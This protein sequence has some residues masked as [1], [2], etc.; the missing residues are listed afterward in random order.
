MRPRV[1][2]HGSSGCQLCPVHPLSLCHCRTPLRACCSA[3]GRWGNRV[4]R[5]LQWEAGSCGG[6]P[7]PDVKA[8]RERMLPFCRDSSPRGAQRGRSP[9]QTWFSQSTLPPQ[10]GPTLGSLLPPLKRGH[11]RLAFVDGAAGAPRC[12]RCELE[13]WV[14]LEGGSIPA[15]GQRRILWTQG[16]EAWCPVHQQLWGA[17]CV[18]WA[19]ETTRVEGILGS[20]GLAP[21]NGG[22]CSCHSSCGWS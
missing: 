2:R 9:F 6:E 12:V 8:E 19:T 21:T 15:W 14:L 10:G 17:C 7:G 11:F 4:E 1:P 5:L 16:L 13:F 18:L 3:S 20:R 22:L